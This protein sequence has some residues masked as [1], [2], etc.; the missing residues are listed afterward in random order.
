MSRGYTQTEEDDGNMVLSFVACGGPI[1]RIPPGNTQDIE[2]EVAV[3]LWA[4]STSRRRRPRRTSKSRNE[5]IEDL[6]QKVGLSEAVD[7]VGTGQVLEAL[8]NGSRR[9]SRE[10]SP[11]LPR[12][13]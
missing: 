10:K 4:P 5:R 13:G 7:L 2:I 9:V 8:E 1:V 12:I 3:S 6:V 11:E